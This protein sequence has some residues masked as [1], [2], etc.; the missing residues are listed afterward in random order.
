MPK[1]LA[2]T[3]Q[4]SAHPWLWQSVWEMCAGA[5][6]GG[7]WRPGWLVCGS[8]GSCSRLSW[9]WWLR[10]WQLWAQTELQGRRGQR[11]HVLPQSLGNV[12]FAGPELVVE[13][14]MGAEMPMHSGTRPSRLVTGTRTGG[15]A[16]EQDLCLLSTALCPGLRKICKRKLDSKLFCLAAGRRHRREGPRG[17]THHQLIKG[18]NPNPGERRA[19]RQPCAPGHLHRLL[20]SWERALCC[21]PK[22]GPNQDFLLFLVLL[23]KYPRFSSCRTKSEVVFTYGNGNTLFLQGLLVELY[24]IFICIFHV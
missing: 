1:Q 7:A 18:R 16:A 23:A 12:T 4:F 6:E 8:E 5:G 22:P 2:G 11:C 9:A 17:V 15:A 20:C 3:R 24:C 21:A 10:P 19:P 14:E 13:F